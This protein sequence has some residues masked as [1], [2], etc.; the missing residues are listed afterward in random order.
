MSEGICIFGEVLFDHFP[1]GRRVLGGAPFNV[2]WHLQ[3]FGLRPLVITRVGAD[4]DGAQVLQAMEAW[5]MDTTGV[6]VDEVNPT[7]SVRVEL[8]L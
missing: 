1:D 4:D 2:A 6:Q 3:A 8:V 7:G 5:G